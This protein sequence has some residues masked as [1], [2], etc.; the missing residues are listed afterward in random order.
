MRKYLYGFYF[1]SQ[2]ELAQSLFLKSY[3]PSTEVWLDVETEDM[4]C[5][6]IQKSGFCFHL[7][8][9]HQSSLYY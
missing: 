7:D 9:G 2:H 1:M 5:L 8:V 3:L 4:L 6:P